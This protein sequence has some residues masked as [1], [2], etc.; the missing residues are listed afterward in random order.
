[1]KLCISQDEEKMFKD[2]LVKR[3]KKKKLKNPGGRLNNNYRGHKEGVLFPMA[4][5]R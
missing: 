1:M 2:I 5:I 3:I 4:E